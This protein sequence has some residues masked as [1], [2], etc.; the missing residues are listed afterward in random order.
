MA[1][2]NKPNLTQNIPEG[3]RGGTSRLLSWVNMEEQYGYHVIKGMLASIP[4]KNRI[5]RA[6]D[7]GVGQG[8][9]LEIVRQRYPE[10]E[11][12]GIDFSTA[13]KSLLKKK[14][15]LLHSLDLERESLTFAPE[16][17]DLFI[18]NQVYE[19]IKE[20]FWLS[21]QIAKSLKVGGCC[22]IGVPNICAFHNRVLFNL[23]F[24]PSQ[25]KSYSAHVRGFGPQEIPKFFSV[26]FPK[27]FR[28]LKFAGAQFY[29]FPKP[30]SR[31]LCAIFPSLAHSVFFL[32]QK[33][34]KY[35]GE[36]ILHPQKAALESNFFTGPG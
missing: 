28:V 24:Q 18:A 21:H 19:H 14:G 25:M 9:D 17:I 7:I 22:I 1:R 10:A 3:T 31:M 29:P 2:Q 6:C 5:E 32:M 26:C 30:L 15:I 4:S 34:S 35:E 12:I 20:I 8:D 27:G 13:N 23:G 33:E 16:S 11:L 36:F